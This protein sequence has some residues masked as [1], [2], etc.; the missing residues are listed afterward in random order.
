MGTGTGIETSDDLLLRRADADP[1]AF[2]EFYARHERGV[3]AYV[4][5]RVRAADATVD[6]VAETFAR[7][8]VGR[9][10]FDA[11]RGV[12][13]AWLLGIAANVIR[14]ALERGRIEDDARR[15]LGMQQV[16]LGEAT[17]S[18]V[19]RVVL[20]SKQAVTEAWLAD[21]PPE[22]HEAVRRRVLDEE[23]YEHIAADLRCS[24]AVVRQRVSRGLA[25]LRSNLE[26]S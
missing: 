9:A 24:S 6:V 23:A 4:G 26:H 12:A 20:E 14:G 18:S 19:E 5:R 15:R 2:A 10:S 13:R 3:V 21:L 25:R 22:Q 16:A 7:A 17:L 1:A 11:T 8:Y